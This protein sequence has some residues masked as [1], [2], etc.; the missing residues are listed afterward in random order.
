MTDYKNILETLSVIKSKKKSKDYLAIINT[1]CNLLNEEEE[2]RFGAASYSRDFKTEHLL[3]Q[4][5]YNGK[6][7]E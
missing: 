6:V 1:I 4:V 2:G 3:I 7:L 5:R